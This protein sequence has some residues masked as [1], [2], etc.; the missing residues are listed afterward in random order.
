MS[1]R[2]APSS[3]SLPTVL[4]LAGLSLGMA[5]A[6]SVGTGSEDAGIVCEFGEGMMCTCPSGLA[7][8]SWCYADGTDFGPCECG[9]GEEGV[10]DEVGTT[11]DT[12]DTTGMD[13]TDTTGMDTTDTTTDGGTDT[14]T[15]GGTTDTTTDGGTDTTTGEPMVDEACYLGPNRDHSVCMPLVTPTLPDCYDYPGLY[16]G[17]VNYRSPVRYLDL[18]AVD[19]SA[20][21][22]PNFT[23]DE[24]AQVYK[25]R[26]AVVQP[27][28]V[29]RLQDLRDIVGPINVNSGYRPPCYNAMIG[30]ATWSRHMYGDAFD[31]DP[32][33]VSLAT[34]ETACT[35]NAGF[36]VEYETHVHC[37]WRNTPV[38]VGFFGFPDV[39]PLEVHGPIGAALEQDEES[40]SWMAPAYGFEEGEPLRRWSA[41]DEHDNLL[42]EARGRSFVPPAEAVRV[43]VI[44][45]AQVRLSAAVDAR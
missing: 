12:T 13:T 11:G 37:D 15:D 34:L 27:H 26:Y 16:M 31:L 45:G 17:N 29:E 38:D 19:Q 18:E 43:D 32:I 8:V 24:L 5:L 33:N 40:G 6:C 36:L 9:E 3:R 41:W 25:G 35:N 20:Q 10:A 44:V 23:L 30:G 1:A 2:P 21:V 28:A 4:L 22:A 42:L 7:S 14:T 39:D